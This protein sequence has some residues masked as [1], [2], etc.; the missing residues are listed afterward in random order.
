V[1]V[2][3]V[4]RKTGVALP[5]PNLN[6]CAFV[7]VTVCVCVCVWGHSSHLPFVRAFPNGRGY[8]NHAEYNY[9]FRPGP[10]GSRIQRR[11]FPPKANVFIRRDFLWFSLCGGLSLEI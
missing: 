11:I 9:V 6:G 4:K 2:S 7:T 5:L 10:G 1:A 8:D 3:E